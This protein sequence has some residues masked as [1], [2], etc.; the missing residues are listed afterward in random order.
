VSHA[1]ETDPSFR[2]RI[3]VGR[4]DMTPEVGIYNHNWGS[5]RHEQ[6]ESIHKPLYASAVALSM[7]PDAPPLIL[8]TIDYCW[9]HYYRTFDKLRTPILQ[10]LGLEA[11]QLLLIVTHSHAVPHMDPELENKPGGDKI[12][13]FR[14]KVVQALNEA[15]DTAL[16][17]MQPA[18]L[19]W[20][21]GFSS[22]ARTRDYLDHDSGRILC[23]PNPDG[24]ADGTLLVGR[25]TA[26][27]DGRI[28][29]TLVNYACHPVSLG[30]GNRSISPDY[31]G[32]M[33]ERVQS[34]TGDAP[35]LFL[36]G[37]SGN[38]TPR[39][40][41]SSDP[42][43]ADSNGEILGY[44]AL[45]TLKAMLPPGQ[46]LEFARSESS[47]APLAVWE[48]RPYPVDGVADAAVEYLRLPPKEWPS[49]ASL[50]ASLR[51]EQ[52]PAARTRI[53]RLKEFIQN[54]ESGLGRGFPVW[55]MRLGQSFIVGTPA[56]PFT[57]LQI[58]LRKRFPQL[59]IAVT[60]DTNGSFNY[61][62]PKSY[63]GNGSYEQDCS[64]YGPG[65]L[66]IVIAAAGQLI[67]QM[68]RRTS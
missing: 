15:I 24:V 61:L 45:A 54:F 8:A 28:L 38:Q 34:G 44:A 10:R 9:F 47:G 60:N 19:T 4:R 49:V 43:V 17:T 52:D 41:Y 2:G 35:C 62:P 53:T 33:R 58:E 12:P 32:A 48:H 25:I 67:E 63:Y 20:G 39:D 51:D 13:A 27:N 29:A 42:A 23:G 37:P 55:V 22:L 65:G 11:R 14:A 18:I 46:R 64:D 21:R 66:E 50:E 5:A 36:H 57:D 31:I 68:L 6:A 3:G 40:S 56:E 1:S 26:E 16:A 59:A 30:G 7:S